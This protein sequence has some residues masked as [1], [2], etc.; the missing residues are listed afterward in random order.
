[1]TIEQL[2]ENDYKEY[3]PIKTQSCDRVFQKAIS[4][5]T[6]KKYFIDVEY[7]NTIIHGNEHQGYEFVLNFET[8]K[9]NLNTRFYG[10]ESLEEMEQEIEDFFIRNKFNYYKIKEGS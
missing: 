4:D 9:Y 1:M 5:E 8:D 10:N 3:K 7:F 2:I 6:G